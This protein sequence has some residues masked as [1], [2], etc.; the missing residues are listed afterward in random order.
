MTL[1]IT[2]TNPLKSSSLAEALLA[3]RSAELARLHRGLEQARAGNGVVVFVEG[4]EGVGKTS[5]VDAFV[6]DVETD[7]RVLAGACDDMLAPRPLGP[8]RDMLRGSGISTTAL[9]GPEDREALIE[10]MLETMS[11]TLRPAVVVID[12]AQWA[13][14]ATLDVIRY[15]GR[16]LVDLPAMLIVVFRSGAP[17]HNKHLDRTLGNLAGHNVLRIE[18]GGLSDAVVARLATE[19][20]AEPAEIVPLVAGNPFYLSEVL[21]T[22]ESSLPISV[23]DAV[24]SRLLALPAETQRALELV[25]VAPRGVDLDL[26]EAVVPSAALY[27]E[28][29]ETARIIVVEGGLVRFRHELARRS[30]EHGLGNTRQIGLHRQLLDHL[31][32]AEADPATIV[33]H[34]AAARVRTLIARYGPRAVSQ[35]VFAGDHRGTITLVIATLEVETEI[36]PATLAR[37]HADAAFAYYALN[38]FHDASASAQV[39]VGMWRELNIAEHLANT[40]LLSA[41]MHTMTGRSQSA[42]EAA[43]EAFEILKPLG[44]SRDLALACA[45]IGYLNA[46]EAECD[47][48]FSWCNRAVELARRVDAVD[49]ETHALIYRG[50]A[51]IGLGDLGGF[52]DNTAAIVNARRLDHGDFLSRAASNRAAALIWLGRHPEAGAALDVADEAAREHQLDCL[53][54]HVAVQR[55]H[56]ELFQGRWDEAATRLRG[57]ITTDR[58]PAAAMIIP[59]ALLGRLSIRKGEEN[60]RQHIERAWGMAVESRQSYRIAVAGGARVE[61]AWLD[62]DGETLSETAAVLLPLATKAN[63]TYLRGDVLRYLRRMGEPVT[64][65]AN[66]P[67]GFAEGIAGDWSAAARA[68][69]QAGN[70]FEEAMERLES[71]DVG[72]AFEGL[73][74]LD[75]LGATATAAR[76]RRTLR[77]KG[78]PGIPRGPQRATREIQAPLTPRQHEILALV[79][80]GLTS[81]QIAAVLYLS[82]RTVDNHISTILTRLDV[83]TRAEAVRLARERQ[84]LDT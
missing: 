30:V 77:N 75:D 42:R 28:P 62:D 27:L 67:S 21:A 11:Q 69:R 40:L 83:S 70:P 12:D 74:T 81:P 43:M 65:F 3:E 5:L 8:F 2:T 29:A 64:G 68:W 23:R 13:D 41:R 73:R 50:L 18:L 20:G 44:H 46:T 25:S 34:A 82:R 37:L 31:V 58:D 71:P 33:H 84:W 57:L 6:A 60:G 16:R 24:A 38:R 39:A 35:A 36:E 7:T 4:E 10:A 59:L 17:A 45:M 79:A 1:S 47:A 76:Y 19:S 22:P 54:F 66:C 72:V 56:I 52:E 15:L 80:N 53:R 78:V 49:V 61:M 55:S 14:D 48:A 63:L 51:R 32:S 26:V 9:R